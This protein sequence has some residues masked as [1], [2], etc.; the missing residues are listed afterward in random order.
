MPNRRVE[1]ASHRFKFTRQTRSFFGSKMKMAALA[2]VT[3]AGLVAALLHITNAVPIHNSAAADIR[4]AF[5]D[6]GFADDWEALP[7]ELKPHPGDEFTGTGWGTLTCTTS[8]CDEVTSIPGWSGALPSKHYSGYL[9]VANS[10]RMLHY[11]LQEA[12]A[13]PLDK[14]LVLWLNGGPGASSLIGAFTEMGQLIFNRDSAAESPPKLFRNPFAWTTLAN[15]LYLEVPAG[16]GFSYCVDPADPCHN[17]D[18][19]TAEQNHE[20]LLGFLERYPEYKSRPFYLTGESYAGI[21]LPMLMELILKRGAITNVRGLAIGNGCWGTQAGTNCGDVTGQP[22]TTWKIDAEYFAGRGLISPALKEA[23]DAACGAWIDPL[24][25]TCKEAYDAISEALGEFNI[26]NVDDFC[27]KTNPVTL[28]SF[29][30]LGG[31]FARFTARFAAALPADGSADLPAA[32]R[33]TSGDAAAIEFGSPD[34]WSAEGGD[35]ADPPVG[36]V[37]MW[38]GAEAALRTWRLLP[39]VAIAMHVTLERNITSIYGLQRGF[40]YTIEPL[41]LSPLYRQLADT[42]GLGFLI[43]NGQ[44]DANVPYNGQVQYWA[45]NYTVLE[46]YKPWYK[47]RQLSQ[48]VAAGHVRGHVRTYATQTA[49]KTFQFVTIGGAGHE[50]PTYRPSAALTM[51]HKFVLEKMR[52]V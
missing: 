16:V 46:E 6:G 48:A 7:E 35:E 40:R 29:R 18:T 20:A 30:A 22:G 11:Y 37:Q 26:D 49:G 5:L 17:S 33:T 8:G 23:A 2:S 34:S 28:K 43:Y 19:S 21:Y 25:P 32:A 41:D 42:A 45:K 44:S 31:R 13:S 1:T 15:M 3:R 38:C 12:D 10:T 52:F 24:T 4:D 47:D 14:P 27:A 36:E 39:E 9:P 50:V 51:L